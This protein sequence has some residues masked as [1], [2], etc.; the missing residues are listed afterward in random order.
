MEDKQ[1][2]SELIG[3]NVLLIRMGGELGIKSRRTRRRMIGLLRVNIKELMKVRDLSF[4]IL[5]FRGRLLIVFN[6]PVIPRH[7]I[8]QIARQISGISS[9]SQAFV[10]GSSEEEIL[11]NG[12]QKAAEYFPPHSS[13][14]VRVRREGLHSFS[15]MD[16]AA[17]L[18]SKILESNIP[19][20]KVNLTSP[21]GEIFLDIRGELTFIY[22]EVIS[23]IDG[24]PSTSQGAA[25]ALI[26]PNA[27]SMLSAWLMK[28]RGVKIL[29]LFFKTGKNSEDIFIKFVEA[30]FAP[31]HS[32]ID[33]EPFFKVFK[34]LN[35]LC[36]YC[37][38]ICETISQYYTSEGSAQ[39]FISPTCFNH[40]GESI[41]LEALSAL[42]FQANIAGLRPIQFGFHG[43]E[44]SLEPLDTIPCCSYQKK[45]E[46]T[47]PEQIN[48]EKIKLVLEK[49]KPQ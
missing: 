29:P 34:N 15:S 23:G 9:L 22:S 7:I 27:N 1:T 12:A 48:Y 37:Q 3:K 6:P 43:K 47:L 25:I 8:R 28:K 31:V 11:T 30:N 39:A 18:G 16:I 45:L 46:I 44:P 49:I 36:F 20:L 17:R 21:Q 32:F 24:I 14:A 2:H 26:R 42:E 41:S 33:L 10:V 4:S 13:F 35:N 40:K 38:L 19:G 5:D